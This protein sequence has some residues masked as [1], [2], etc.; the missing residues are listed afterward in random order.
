MGPTDGS[1][2][3]DQSETMGGVET[4]LSQIHGAADHDF[5]QFTTIEFV[6]FAPDQGGNA[7]QVGIGTGRTP[8]STD[9]TTA[10]DD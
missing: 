7:S 10:V 5:A 6:V 3:V 8:E 2:S 1:F 4:A 9:A